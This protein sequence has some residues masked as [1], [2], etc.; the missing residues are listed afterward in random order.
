M[1]PQVT[2]MIAM[3]LTMGMIGSFVLI[4]MRMRIQAKRPGAQVDLEDLERLSDAVEG[5]TEQVRVLSDE[6]SDL[7]ERVDF[8]ERLLTRGR[9]QESD[10]SALATPV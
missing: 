4:G 5:L 9:A 3:V 8:A 6:C 1:T 10:Q 7:G 2:E